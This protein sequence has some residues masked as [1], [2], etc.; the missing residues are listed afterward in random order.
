M[1]AGIRRGIPDLGVVGVLL[2]VVA[3]VAIVEVVKGALEANVGES[4]WLDLG[5]KDNDDTDENARG[6]LRLGRGAWTEPNGSGMPV[7]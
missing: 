5:D 6:D 2:V 1:R 3:E 4:A 7:V